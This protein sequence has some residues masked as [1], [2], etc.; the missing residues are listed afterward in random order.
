LE[1]LD[2]VEIPS[3]AEASRPGLRIPQHAMSVLVVLLVIVGLVLIGVLAELA[4]RAQISGA[5][6]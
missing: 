4:H 2:E 1:H 6:P 5:A 3:Y